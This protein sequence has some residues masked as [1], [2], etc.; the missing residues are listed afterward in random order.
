MR[1][2]A[3][4]VAV[5]LSLTAPGCGYHRSGYNAKLPVNVK[6]VAV[7]GFTNSTRTYRIEQIVTAAVV[8]E[9]LTRTHYSITHDEGQ[10]ADAIL[11]GAILNA[12]SAPATYDSKTGRAASVA[13]TVYAR[14]TLTTRDGKVLYD[15]PSYVFRDQ[16]QL[17]ND[18]SSFFEEDTPTMQR[19]SR[20]FA[21]T[22]VSNIL[23]DF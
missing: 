18:L 2:I 5:L 6:T 20:D 10:N 21:R 3:F 4:G 9:F 19:M 22:L 16:Y 7:P 8:Q 13:V 23:E 1:V 15:N 14:V 17:T 11:R 12:V